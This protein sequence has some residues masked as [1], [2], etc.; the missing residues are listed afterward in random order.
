[1]KITTIEHGFEYQAEQIFESMLEDYN[2]E[3]VTRKVN[4]E[5]VYTF[6]AWLW[7]ERETLGGLFYERLDEWCGIDQMTEKYNEV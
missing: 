4:E 1:M 3:M 5:P 7:N 6:R 2:H